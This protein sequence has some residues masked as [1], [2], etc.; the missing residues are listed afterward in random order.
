[1]EA[2]VAPFVAYRNDPH[3]ARYQSWES[4]TLL[5]ATALVENQKTQAPGTPGEWYQ[6]AIALKTTNALVGDCALRV[7]APDA[8]QATIGITL[9]RANQGQGF[10][11]EALSS[12]FDSLFTQLRLHRVV[13]DTDPLNTP[14]WTLLERLGMRREGHMIQSLWFKGHWADEYYYAILREEWLTKRGW[15]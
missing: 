12:L 14:S 6:I 10:A 4:C 7:H 9:A 2:D 15:S 11:T 1:M 5:E 8:R 13:A 3:V